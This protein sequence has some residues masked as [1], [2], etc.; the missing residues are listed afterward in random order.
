MAAVWLRSLVRLRAGK[1]LTGNIGSLCEQQPLKALRAPCGPIPQYKILYH[2][3][4]RPLLGP[5]PAPPRPLGGPC[6]AG[7]PWPPS[8]QVPALWPFLPHGRSYISLICP[9][10]GGAWASAPSPIP[11][12]LCAPRLARLLLL[13]CCWLFW[14]PK[15][16][17]TQNCSDHTC[18]RQSEV[19][20]GVVIMLRRKVI[21]IMR[22][23][24]RRTC[25]AHFDGL[26]PESA[27]L[28]DGHNAANEYLGLIERAENG[29]PRACANW[30]APSSGQ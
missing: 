18:W 12:P 7:R 16:M 27:K 8:L 17:P 3:I 24:R 22:R 29:A 25:A 11:L 26:Q 30:T 1:L 23:I 10:P 19:N 14:T 15:L 20:V 9:G 28:S 21:Q 5:L 4:T 6:L 13:R 2:Y